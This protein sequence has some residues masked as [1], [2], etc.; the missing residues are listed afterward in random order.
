MPIFPIIITLMIG[1]VYARNKKKNLK[2]LNLMVLYALIILV[3]I[4][5]WLIRSYAAVEN[6]FFP[7]LNSV[8]T[9]DIIKVESNLPTSPNEFASRKLLGE[10]SLSILLIPFRMFFSGKDNDLLGGFGGVLNPMLLIMFIP[11]LFPKFRSLS[12][13]NK[14]IKY[15]SVIFL[16]TLAFFLGYGHLRI[17]YFIYSMCKWNWSWILYII[18]FKK[19]FNKQNL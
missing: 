12:S 7:L 18:F 8:F 9:P 15:P 14:V 11:L 1:L 17:R 3:V 10:S 5:P 6:P 19:I 2:A 13:S 4:S 16:L